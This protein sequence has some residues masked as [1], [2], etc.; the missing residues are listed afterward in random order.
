MESG[1]TKREET[2]ATRERT[3]CRTYCIYH[4]I[5]YRVFFYYKTF[6]NL[7]NRL[8]RKAKGIVVLEYPTMCGLLGQCSQQ[9]MSPFSNFLQG[10]HL[11]LAFVS[12]AVKRHHDHG[13]SY[14]GKHLIE[15][16]GSPAQA[17]VPPIIKKKGLSKS[18]IKLIHRKG[19]VATRHGISSHSK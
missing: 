11:Y 15:M 19:Q 14:E 1:A 9:A 7:S 16:A 12:I 18:L 17:M 8:Q 2:G 5:W 3:R 4:N 13:N 6:R 10:S